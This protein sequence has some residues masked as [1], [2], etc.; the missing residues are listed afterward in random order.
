MWIELKNQGKFEVVTALTMI[1]ASVKVTDDPIGLFGSGTK[2]ALAQALRLGIRVVFQVGSVRYSLTSVR[3]DFRGTTFDM[4][5]LA[6]MH[7]PFDSITAT[8]VTGITSQFGKEDWQDPWFIFREFFS[9]GLDEVGFEHQVVAELPINPTDDDTT[10]VYLEYEP[11]AH[12]YDNLSDYFLDSREPAIWL[13]AN[14]SDL[15]RAYK[16]GVYVGPAVYGYNVSSENI[17]LNECRVADRD[18]VRRAVSR[19][20]NLSTNPEL[21]ERLLSPEYYDVTDLD[22]NLEKS[23][24]IVI[25]DSSLCSDTC[26]SVVLAKLPPTGKPPIVCS[27]G[28]NE[29]K[30][31]L[32]SIGLPFISLPRGVSI[33]AEWVVTGEKELESRNYVQ[34]NSRERKVIAAVLPCVRAAFGVELP[35]VTF[36][37][38]NGSQMV[39]G[40]ANRS[41]REISINADLF[42]PANGFELVETLI[43]EYGHIIS[44]SGDYERKFVNCF[45]SALTRLA[46]ASNFGGESWLIARLTSLV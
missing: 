24:Q 20:L 25:S 43:H 31:T 35:V 6:E 22:V 3:Q 36:L 4:V 42:E 40:Q 13:T 10:R 2:Y 38:L 37:K 12:V 14:T 29:L 7:A 17:S 46:V 45:T 44:N 30:D 1:G 8:H 5:A 41:K 34:L 39:S 15:G 23:L 16:L 28:D 19:R 26:K 27:H 21:F 32:K 33:T 18:S 11:L 9:N